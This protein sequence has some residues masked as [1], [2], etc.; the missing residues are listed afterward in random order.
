MEGSHHPSLYDEALDRFSKSASDRY[1]GKELA[2]LNEFLRERATPE[3]TKQAAEALQ[4]DAGK[5][6]GG[7]KVGDVEIP[8]S[9]IANI[10]TNINNF[11]TAGDFVTTGAP[12]SVGMAWYAVK[13]TLTAIHSNYELYTFFGSGLSD[14]SE[15]MIIVRHYDRLYDERSKSNWKPSP[16]VEKLFQD[17]ISAYAAVLDFSFAIKRHLTAGALTRIKHGFKDFFGISKAKFEDKLNIVTTLKKKILEESQGA[18]QDKTLTQLQDVSVALAGIE[19]TVR[20]ITDIQESQQKLRDE[21][22]AKFDLLLKGLDDIKASTKRKTQWDYAVGDFQTY[23]ETLNP[24]EGSFKILGDVIDAIYPGTCQWVFEEDAYQ[25]WETRQLNRMLCITGP[26]GC[27]KSYVVATIADRITRTANEDKALLYVSCKGSTGD[28]AGLSNNQSYTADSICRTFLS[29]LYNLAPQ[30]EDNVGLL[31]ACNAV[32]KKA[33]AKNNNLPAHMR[34]D[35]IGL[36]E[37]A[38]GFTKLAALLKKDVVLV[39]DGLD[40]NSMDDRNQEELLRKLKGL[41]AATSEPASFRLKILVGCGLS[42]KIFNDLALEP[43]A[44]IDVGLGN[45]QDIELVVTDALK[46]VPGLSAAEQE[47]AKSAITAKARS[48]FLYVKNTAIPFMR[49]PF[50]RPLSKR[51]KVLPDDTGDTYSKALRKMSPNYLELLRT[52]LTWS[53]LSPDPPGYPFAR[54]VMDA[55]QGTYDAPPGIDA[56]EDADVEPNFPP[57]SGLEIEQLRGA[58]DPFLK[59]F[60]SPDGTYFVAETDYETAASFFL[61][62][63]TDVPQEEE[64]EEQLCGRCRADQYPRRIIVDPKEGH[65]QMALTCLRHLNNPLFQKRAGLLPVAEKRAQAANL[66]ATASDSSGS[67]ADTKVQSQ[68]EPGGPGT[69]QQED[70]AAAYEEE[71]QAGYRTEDSM[72]D[73]DVTKP[74][75]F[76]I[77][78]DEF[79]GNGG[80]DSVEEDRRPP[81]VRY[82]IQYWPYHVLESERLW[83][84]EERKTNGHWAALLSELDKFAF[85]TPE[86][87]AAWQ[88]KY[89]DRQDKSLFSV[90]NGPH[91]PLHVASYLGLTSWIRHLLDRGEDLNGLSGGYSPLQVAACLKGR[92]ETIK[93]LLTEGADPNAQ[94]G[95]GRSAFHTWLLKGE[96]NIEGVQMMLDHGADPVSSSSKEHWAALQYFAVKGEDPEVLDLLI[97]HG[98]DINAIDAADVFKL[99]PLHV[100]LCR[101][102]TP[103]PLLDAFVKRN[104]DTN[105]ENAGS[106]RPLQI[107]CSTGQVENLKILLGSEVLELDDPDLHGTTAVHEAVFFG[108]SNCVR[109]LLKHGADPDIPDKLSRVALHTAARKGLI[110]CVRILLEYTKELN[111]LDKHGWSP[112][113]SACLSKNEEAA[114]ALLDALIEHNVSLAEI[115]KP[116]RSGRSPLRQ[117]AGHGFNRVVSRLVKLAEERN[118]TAALAID[119]V[120]T[121]KSMT[122]LHRA[123]MNGHASTV[124]AL[125]A[126]TPKPDVTIQDNRSRTALTLA[127]EQWALARR[128]SSYEEI[129]LTLVNANPSAAVSDPELVAVCA[130]NGSTKLLGQLARLNADFNRPDRFGWTP[131]ELARNFSQAEA[132]SF[133]KQQATWSNLLPTRWCTQFPGTTVVGAQSVVLPD[134]RAIV[135]TSGQRTCVSADKPLPS[136]LESY[137]FE[138]TLTEIP[139]DL[140]CAGTNGS[141]H[142]EIAVGF[143][144]LGGAAIQFPGWQLSDDNPSGAKSWAYY[145]YTGNCCQS[146]EKVDEEILEDLRYGV[147]DTVGCGVDLGKGEVWFTRNAMK[148]EKGFKG[149]RGRLFPIVGLHDPVAVE[150]N[151]GG[152]GREFMWKGA[153]RVEEEEE[154][155]EEI[156]ELRGEGGKTFVNLVIH[157]AADRREHVGLKKNEVV[158]TSEEVVVDVV[159]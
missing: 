120:D 129:I 3:E 11:I 74:S 2:L 54:E 7:R 95:V 80:S 24:L 153:V 130:A 10:M 50:K 27:G 119:A 151:F 8:E 37:F 32:F 134:A 75:I 68:T 146:T 108:H 124:R 159:A 26:E 154:V 59:L 76:D 86:I 29:Q 90:C 139:A 114:L 55:F 28:G 72:D 36:P 150:V 45:W 131:L 51:L 69:Q 18:F 99:P 73:E 35:N 56:L 14:I 132:E 9:W 111:P 113:F 136:G 46:E 70:K 147:G 96:G 140:P 64:K 13:L 98:A 5:K 30:G 122:A 141:Q 100:L 101:T 61:K 88:A 116:T 105:A 92:L 128:N 118:D 138:L 89:P 63:E 77:P 84:P 81:R 104:A 78:A 44:Y 157:A 148:L 52:T 39:L 103:G 65:L 34:H 22:N 58:V 83:S 112:F 149:V 145:G 133:L 126:A 19:G 155:V 125:L 21:A 33:K 67:E 102:D 93:L 6:Y 62:S 106:A 4:A 15:I 42:T 144:T 31:E 158:V 40:R 87:F 156:E 79:W 97:A 43:D 66:K 121:K 25:N 57:V 60:R 91:K 47:E 143:C 117:A 48:R 16:L 107:V 85:D 41:V 137:Y 109:I 135:H 94:N 115:N 17:V 142:L 127:Y 20:H 110:D 53:L 152:S 38:D 23:Q 12:E 1:T 82:E 49:E 71:Y 123:A